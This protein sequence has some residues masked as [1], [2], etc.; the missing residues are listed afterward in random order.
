MKN[1]GTESMFTANCIT[2][3]HTLPVMWYITSLWY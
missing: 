3:L 1:G 2:A